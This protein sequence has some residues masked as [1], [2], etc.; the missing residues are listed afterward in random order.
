MTKNAN[1][2]IECSRNA[3]KTKSLFKIPNVFDLLR[4]LPS[5]KI[6]FDLVNAQ[7]DNRP[8]IV[9]LSCT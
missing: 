9:F 7:T 1:S 3:I 6:Y 8:S 5:F 4:K 2:H